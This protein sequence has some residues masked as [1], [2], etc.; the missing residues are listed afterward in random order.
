MNL[1]RQ[2][3][4]GSLPR[5]FLAWTIDSAVIVVPFWLLTAILATVTNRYRHG[6][7]FSVGFVTG[8]LTLLTLTTYRAWAESTKGA[9]LGKSLAGLRVVDRRTGEAPERRVAI[10]R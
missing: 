1:Q 5:R 9:T 7:D 2:M 4:A 10:I 8:P 6:E 3:V